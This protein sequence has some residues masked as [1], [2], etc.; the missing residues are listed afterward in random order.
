[1][2]NQTFKLSFTITGLPNLVVNSPISVFKAYK[3]LKNQFQLNF[4]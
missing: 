2:K 1:M 3:R 4:Q